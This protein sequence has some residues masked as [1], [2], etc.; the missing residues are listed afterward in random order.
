MSNFELLRASDVCLVLECSGPGLPSVVH[1]G[2]DLGDLDADGLAELAR[3]AGTTHVGTGLDAAPKVALVPEYATGW[4]GLPGLTGHRD[5]RDFSPAFQLTGVERAGNKLDITGEDTA[6]ALAIAIELQLT[7]SGLLK[8]QAGLTNTG[9]SPYTVDG[10]VIALPVPTEA[11]ELLDLTGRWIGERHPQRHAFTQGA[12]IRDGRRGRTGADAS[13]LLAA[14]TPGFCFRSGEVW[15]VHTAWSGNHRTYAERHM[16][17]YAVIGGGELLLPGEV[18]MQAGET[19]STPVI[20]GS[21][22]AGL[23]DVSRRFHDFLRSRPHHP[24]SPRPVVLNT[25]EAVYF[26]HDLDKLT[27]LADA[28]AEVGA[29]RFVLDDGWFRYRRADNAGLG[30]WFVDPEVWP[31]GLNPLVEHVT[32]LGM[33][34]GLWV[35]PEMLNTD[36]DLAR[37]HPEWILAA[38]NRLP[39][40]QR[41]QQVLNIGIP[42][43]YDYILERL[44]ALLTEY[45]ISYLK[46]DH[47]RDLVDAG[48]Q[49]TG[50]AGVHRQTQATYR[51]FAELKRRHPGLEIESCSSGGARADLGILDRSDRIWASDCNDALE[52]QKIQRWTQLLLPPELIGSHVGPPRAH[53]TR[54]TQ[55]LAFRAATALFGHFGIEWDISSATEQERQE[56]K[57]WVALYKELRSLIHT[58]KVVRAD[59]GSEELMVHGVVAQD[60]RRAVYAVAQ[61]VQSITSELG[62]VRLPGLEPGQN[63]RV[64][65]LRTPGPGLELWLVRSAPWLTEKPVVMSGAALAAVGVVMPAQVPESALL[66]DVR[67]V[68]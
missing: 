12:H 17:G 63:Y 33:Q 1:W 23:D 65:M 48:D 11:T 58:G 51:L 22:G 19:Y 52:R 27:A 20:Y 45:D 47:N 13:L 16:S 39:P 21:Y 60:G 30:D 24:R 26:D 7:D 55:S 3:G 38:G 43:A 49:L 8:V 66:L 4:P 5:G 44:D 25:W 14:G 28:A 32:G 36:S 62:R 34:F 61:L 54:R 42:E 59:R 64:S 41:H 35:E 9:E 37:A 68:D 29:E 10:L 50:T 53:T 15:G 2:A 18:R 6:A 46:W 40:E 67:A 57:G 56:L 31:K